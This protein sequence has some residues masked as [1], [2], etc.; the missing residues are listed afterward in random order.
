MVRSGSSVDLLAVGLLLHSGL[1]D[2]SAAEL[3]SEICDSHRFVDF[4]LRSVTYW[5]GSDDWRESTGRWCLCI[6]RFP[7]RS[8]LGTQCK[9]SGRILSQRVIRSNAADLDEASETFRFE[10]TSHLHLSPLQDLG[11][12]W[13]PLHHRPQHQFR[14]GYDARVW[15]KDRHI[16]LDYTWHGLIMSTEFLNY[17]DIL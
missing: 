16:S 7:G 15:S 5:G 14:G 6:W 12:T 13:Y 9:L 4:R 8:P 2:G 1:L 3:C 10:T 11:E 17:C